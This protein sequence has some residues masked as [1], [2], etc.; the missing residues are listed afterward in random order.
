M[1]IAETRDQAIEDCTYGLEDFANYF[2]GGA[3]F[4]P[5]A[6]KVD[7]EP[8]TERE[9]VEA[10][11]EAGGVVIGTPDDAIEYIEGLSSSPAASARSSCSATTGPTRAR[12]IELVP[13]VRRE[14]I[15]HFQG[16]LQRAARRRTTGPPPKRGELFGR[17]GQAIMNAITDPRRGEGATADGRGGEA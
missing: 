1:H 9:F 17:A 4:V 16:Q 11:A 5:L 10:Y 6:N 13:A 7:G 15:P 8:D 3:G 2:G 12:R 14:V